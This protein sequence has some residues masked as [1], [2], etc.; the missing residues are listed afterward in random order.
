LGWVMNKS[1]WL[2]FCVIFIFQ[3]GCATTYQKDSFTGGFSETQLSENVWRVHFKGNAKT[4]MERATDFCLLRS[5]ELTIENGFNYFSLVD[6][7]SDTKT[8]V[9]TTPMTAQT[10]AYGYT[11]FSGGQTFAYRK[12]RIQN[13]VFMLKEKPDSAGMVYEAI[14]IIQSIQN[15]YPGEFQKT[16]N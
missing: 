5:A 2:L 12:P 6:E 1:I 16:G 15:K 9:I 7:K 3:M 10:S 14:F 8:G 4:S 11:T 13:T